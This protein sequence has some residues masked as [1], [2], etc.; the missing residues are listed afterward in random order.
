MDITI[1]PRKLAGSI[2][3]IP[4]K[5]VA[6]RLLI[7][8]AF[9]DGP[10]TLICP[11]V[12]RDMEATAQCLN[13]LGAS[14]T[15]ENGAFHVVPA[16]SIPKDAI[17][18]CRDSGST[19]RFLLPVAGALGVDAT[20]QMEG[21]LPQR[22]LSPLWEEMERMG[23]TLSRP[24]E[25]TLLCSGKLREGA[26]TI[27]GSVSSQ[28]ITGLLFALN[29]IA[30]NS[31]LEITGKVESR[32]YIT[33]TQQALSQ[34]G[35]KLRRSPGTLTVE[36][37]WS[38]AAFFLAANALGSTLDIQG[39]REDSCQGDRAAVNWISRLQQSFAEISA[40]DIP[41]LVPILSIVAAASKGA[42][43]TDIRRLRLKESDRVAATVSMLEGLGCKAEATEDALTVHPGKFLGGTVD[44]VNDHRIAMAAAIAATVC[45]A[46][47]TILGAQCTEKSYPLF[48]EE[49]SRLGGNYEQYLR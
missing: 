15:Y 10:T 42:V 7:C 41:D 37:D 23:C 4:S 29:L 43:F 27:D 34:F 19:L 30:G 24:T 49:Y 18:P 12:N 8:A 9:A 39:L 16:V 2:Q 17:L 36:G 21:R 13:A 26:Y 20:F 6:H 22:P 3:V 47:V 14:I 32:P 33:I 46:P 48:W 44:A 28:F 31:T 38:N 11:A 5:S 40:A 45:E 35:G 25:N 1:N